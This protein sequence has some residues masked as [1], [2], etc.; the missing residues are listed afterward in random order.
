M[1]K[2]C[3][4][5]PQHYKSM[6]C[7]KLFMSVYHQYDALKNIESQAYSVCHVFKIYK[8]EIYTS[9]SIL[10]TLP[11]KMRLLSKCNDICIV[12]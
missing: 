3:K 1:V 10:H 12:R 7:A 4:L 9:L 5:R 2:L 8:S 6:Y 11:A